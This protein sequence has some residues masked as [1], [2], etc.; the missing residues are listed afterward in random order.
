MD[1]DDQ[2]IGKILSRRE[3]L[4]T[5]GMAGFGLVLGFGGKKALAQQTGPK[6]NLVATPQL[7]EG[8][9]F[10]DKKLDRSNLIGDSKRPGVVEGLPLLLKF[11]VYE[12]DGTQ[13]DPLK[14]AMV[15]VWHCDADGIYSGEPSNPI[16]GEDTSG[17]YWLRGFQMT[18]EK[19][20]V[21]FQTIYPG[22]YMGRA[23]HIHFKI[24]TFSPDGKETYEFTSQIFFDE[25]VYDVLLSK[26]PY[27]KRDP[28]RRVMNLR[29]GIYSER[30]M[31]GSRAGSHLTAELKDDPKGRGKIA[32]FTVAFDMDGARR[33]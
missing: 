23:I 7:T 25:N 20:E 28:S 12:L 24:R 19:G 32:A 5:A 17:E 31:D 1:H 4:M 2:T 27:N 3:A 11:K 9:F 8:P 21:E 14:G 15:D 13:G 29:D 30:Q 16:Q 22:F 33:S 26:E 10:V 6:L 18:D